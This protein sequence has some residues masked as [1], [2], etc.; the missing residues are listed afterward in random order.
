MSTLV[1]RCS[2]RIS[3]APER[4]KGAFAQMLAL[5]RSNGTGALFL[6]LAPISWKQGLFWR[7]AQPH[8]SN[9]NITDLT[10][11]IPTTNGE[12]KA[13]KFASPFAD[14]FIY[15]RQLE[16]I[17]DHMLCLDAKGMLMKAP[18]KSPDPWKTRNQRGILGHI[19]ACFLANESST[20]GNPH[21]HLKLY[22]PMSWNFLEKGAQYADFSKRV[23][24]YFDSFISNEFSSTRTY[25]VTPP[26]AF[27]NPTTIWF[28][29][30][31]VPVPTTS[32]LPISH[33]DAGEAV[34]DSFWSVYDK[35][36]YHI[37][38]HQNHNFSCFKNGGL[39]CRFKL[40]QHAWNQLS[41]IIQLE[42]IKGKRKN[43]PS[44]FEI[45]SVIQPPSDPNSALELEADKRC[46]IYCSTKRTDDSSLL[47]DPTNPSKT[48]FNIEFQWQNFLDIG[49]L[50]GLVSPC[51]AV[52]LICCGGGGHLH[53]NL[54]VVMKG[55]MGEN[56]YI[57]KYVT[58]GVGQLQKCL[59]LLY[60]AVQKNKSSVHPDLESNPHRKYLA[61]LQQSI[62]NGTKKNEFSLPIML[63]DLMGMLQFACSHG[64]T[65]VH[66][67][68]LRKRLMGNT[69]FSAP[70]PTEVTSEEKSE[71]QC[72]TEELRMFWG[73]DLL[74]VQ[75][76]DL[77]PGGATVLVKDAKVS[78]V[79]IDDDY[80]H[81][82][83]ALKD[84]NLMEYRLLVS[85]EQIPTETKK[86]NNAGRKPN[87][88]F[89]F[90]HLMA[91]NTPPHLQMTSHWQV[92]RSTLTHMMLS[93]RYVPKYPGL[94]PSDKTGYQ[95]SMIAWEKGAEDF[96]SFFVCLLDPHELETGLP[97]Y[98]LSFQG[99][100]KL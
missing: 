91:G 19:S 28:Q 86:K 95:K 34:I 42:L 72:G 68:Q 27:P 94:P 3:F 36:G 17:L 64:F 37:V 26:P 11:E 20:D 74:R 7:L 88:R 12:R 81:R 55:G 50:N 73:G 2:K 47:R 51:S 93:G 6:T 15:L 4:S 63:L 83:E 39:V 32:K 13:A 85:K 43:D 24:E 18:K 90:E 60:E 14:C 56:S 89:N 41:G 22:T 69:A 48:G 78:V 33:A 57:A 35:E 9:C 87:G 92:L 40:P 16:A 84:F 5:N 46:L 100:P 45:F 62:N 44:T 8:I 52:L 99:T 38:H 30:A 23:G 10:T 80:R 79:S 98:A 66:V 82:G 61:L 53:N 76:D 70:A 96:G 71:Y 21:A 58:K 29:N 49:R 77:K 75:I 54:Q 97:T 59:P 67:D 1:L 31:E 65:H 25:E